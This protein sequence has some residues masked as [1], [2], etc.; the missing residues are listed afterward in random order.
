[1][2]PINIRY[3]FRFGKEL[4]EV[5]EL[6]LDPDTIEL[7]DNIPDTLPDWTRLDFY[8]CPHC[9]LMVKDH[10]HCPVATNL[11]NVLERFDTKFSYTE[12]HIVVT[13]KERMISQITTVQRGVSSLIGL[14]I[15]ASGCPHTIF[16]K[17]MARFHLPLADDK[18]TT[19]RAVSMYLLAQY[20]L[21][22]EGKEIDFELKG[23]KEIY[24]NIQLVNH[25]VA[26]R[27]RVASKTDSVLNALVEL[28]VYAQT[29]S[30]VI[31]RSLD[32]LRTLFSPYL[33]S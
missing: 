1:M 31:E 21:K 16:F 30:L 29:L 28:D 2:E 25:T 9:P 7:L 13:T 5:V 10:P 3:S 8:Q 14:V 24:H 4:R 19:Y 11:V 23:L 20:F 6:K 26:Q 22:K 32:E 27:L 18:E 15:A 12:T 33:A 17:P